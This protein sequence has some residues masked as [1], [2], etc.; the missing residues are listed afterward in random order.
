[1][2]RTSQKLLT[3]FIKLLKVVEVFESIQGEGLMIG[4]P[5]I[6][7]RLAGCNLHCAE[8]DTK[9][10]WAISP[11]NKINTHSVNTLFDT[12]KNTFKCKNICITGGEPLLQQPALTQLTKLLKKAGYNLMVETNGTIFPAKELITYIDFWSVSPKLFSMGTS[13]G[14]VPMVLKK[15]VNLYKSKKNV[16][17]KFVIKNRT[18]FKFI[19]QFL[20]LYNIN[21]KMPIILQPNSSGIKSYKQYITLLK[22]L[23]EETKE[24]YFNRLNLRVLPQ[25]HWLIWK[26][27]KGV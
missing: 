14:I 15:Y 6:F 5:Y 12:I 16:Q 19:N 21:K 3:P 25:L 17:F 27:K 7:I 18:D 1:M 23:V 9:H 26:N 8:C 22:M 20:F 11:R 24:K 2:K 13:R 4:Q 10:S